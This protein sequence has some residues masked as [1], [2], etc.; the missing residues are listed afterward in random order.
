MP[1]NLSSRSGTAADQI[2]AE[3]I[4]DFINM[5]YRKFSPD[6]QDVLCGYLQDLI[7]T[8]VGNNDGNGESAMDQPS[9]A[10]PLLVVGALASRSWGPA[11]SRRAVVPA[12]TTTGATTRMHGPYGNS[13]NW[14]APQYWR[15]RPPLWCS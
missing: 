13:G 8:H 12:T 6:E 15:R 7:D 1:A 2:T 14:G 10:A 3:R 9:A 5:G 4:S 11:I